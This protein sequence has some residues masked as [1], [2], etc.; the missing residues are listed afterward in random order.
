MHLNLCFII[1]FFLFCFVFFLNAQSSLQENMYY[2]LKPMLHENT[3]RLC[4]P[5]TQ[6]GF[7]TSLHLKKKKSIPF[8]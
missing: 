4:H 2:G 5:I 8:E 6:Y 7:K 3:I 1:N